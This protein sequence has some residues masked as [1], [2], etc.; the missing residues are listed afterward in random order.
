MQYEQLCKRTND[1]KLKFIETQLDR[2]EIA[3]R[4]N[5]E[6]FHAPILEVDTEYFINA[7]EILTIIDDVPDDHPRWTNSDKFYDYV[8]RLGQ[9]HLIWSS[10]SSHEDHNCTLCGSWALSINR[11]G[12][13]PIK[14]REICKECFRVSYAEYKEATSK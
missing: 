10:D 11:A 14:Q 5:G 1:P 3:H 13:I 7:L 8:R 4:R 9:W 12:L 2:A 6:S